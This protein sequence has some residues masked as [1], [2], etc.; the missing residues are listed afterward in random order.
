MLLLRVELIWITE[1]IMNMRK[2]LF[3]I[4]SVAI[5]AFSLLFQCTA[6]FYPGSIPS[7]DG[8]YNCFGP[9]TPRLNLTCFGSQE[10][11][12]LYYK[13]NGIDFMTSPLI[14]AQV[15]ELQIEDPTMSTYARAFFLD[16][17]M[18]GFDLNLKRFPTDD[19][20]FRKALAHMFDK[21]SFVAIQL[22]GY[23]MPMD[24]PLDWSSDW[25]NPYC[26]D[27][28]PYDLQAAVDILIAHGYHDYDDDFIVEGP[29]GTE[30]ELVMYVRG[31]E[32]GRDTMMWI[33]NQTLGDYLASCDWSPY[34]PSVIKNSLFFAPKAVCDQ[35]VMCEFD[36]N[37]YGGEWRFDRDDPTVMYC[38]Y[39]SSYAQ[40]FTHTP[41]YLGYEN[42]AFDTEVEGMLAATEIGDPLTPGTAKYHVHRMQQILMDDVGVIPVFTYAS[43]GGYRTGWEK[44]VNNVGGTGPSSWF[45]FLNTYHQTATKIRRGQ[46]LMLV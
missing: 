36:Y 15:D 42:A 38:M 33:L 3:P 35:K 21:D 9:M 2:A 7:D 32:E 45:T 23:A 41:N 18:V 8:K 19:I 39:H 10:T 30:F 25:Y 46:T 24:S 26:D 16:R 28:Y 31:G 4:V 22:G 6:F 14:A 1:E 40:A 11:E 17:G 12:Y 37:I 44:V 5:L 27:L 43:F 29:G 20:Y 13:A 34:N